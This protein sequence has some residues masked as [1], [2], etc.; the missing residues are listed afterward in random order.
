MNPIVEEIVKSAHLLVEKQYEEPITKTNPYL[1]N[2]SHLCITNREL[3][4]RIPAEDAG[5]LGFAYMNIL[6]LTEDTSVHQIYSSI[7]F[8]YNEK[9]LIYAYTG[10]RVNSQ[11]HV[12]TLNDSIILLNF[13]K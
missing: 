2:V 13:R 6:S 8:Y 11:M 12:Q 3:M 10:D 5:Y 1:Y 4:G 9:A 7:C